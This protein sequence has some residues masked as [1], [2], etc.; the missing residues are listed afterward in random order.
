MDLKKTNFAH[1]W[2]S[3]RPILMNFYMVGWEYHCISKVTSQ[4]TGRG[5]G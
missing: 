5:V 3:R 2:K 4:V 1:N